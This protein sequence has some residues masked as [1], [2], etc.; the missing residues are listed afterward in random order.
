[1]VRQSGCVESL[2]GSSVVADDGHMTESDHTDTSVETAHEQGIRAIVDAAPTLT[3]EGARGLRSIVLAARAPH[4][5]G[6]RDAS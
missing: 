6:Q 1:M 2:D 3:P 5:A 4:E